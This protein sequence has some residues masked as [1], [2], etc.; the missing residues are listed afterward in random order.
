MVD[1]N[2]FMGKRKVKLVECSPSFNERII[3]S[4]ITGFFVLVFHKTW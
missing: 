4:R 2:A 3:D 1:N